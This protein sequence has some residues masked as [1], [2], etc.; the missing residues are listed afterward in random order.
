VLRHFRR[1]AD[2]KLVIERYIVVDCGRQH[3][4]AGAAG[5]T[6]LK[7]A[8]FSLVINELQQRFL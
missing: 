3:I 5:G 6:S 8:S 1:C 2:G 4:T 7:L